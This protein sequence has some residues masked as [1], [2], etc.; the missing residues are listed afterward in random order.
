MGNDN[1]LDMLNR[2]IL[3]SND[4]IENFGQE[5]AMHRK[6]DKV[7]KKRNQTGMEVLEKIPIS[8]LRQEQMTLQNSREISRNL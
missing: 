5:A 2:K 4:H 3:R 8:T 6:G 1:L 7:R